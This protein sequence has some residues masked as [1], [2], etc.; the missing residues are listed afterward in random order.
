MCLILGNPVGCFSCWCSVLVY[1]SCWCDVRCYVVLHYYIILLYYIHIHIIIYYT[2]IYYILY[3]TL[4]F[5]SLPFLSQSISSHLPRQ[6]FPILFF[7]FSPPLQFYSSPFPSPPN[8]LP[9]YLLFLP[10][11]LSIII[12]LS[13]FILYVSA[14][15]YPY[16]Y[17]RLIQLLTPHV[18]SEWMVEVWCV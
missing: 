10:S 7:L 18:L 12:H 11:Y 16:L 1:V 4:I 5:S 15:G 3:Y 14:F 8:P 17:S 2:I 9:I 6:S 13:H